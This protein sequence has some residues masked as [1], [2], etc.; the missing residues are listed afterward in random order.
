MY[1]IGVLG[2]TC[3]QMGL[4]EILKVQLLGKETLIPP[5]KHITRY[6]G[7]YILYAVTKG[8]L[9]LLVNGERVTLNPGD[10]FLFNKG[11]FQTPEEAVYCEY[12]YLH[13]DLK[14]IKTME[15]SD[16]DYQ[17]ET[18]R[19]QNAYWNTDTYSLD[20]YENFALLI[21]QKNHIA[22]QGVF[23]Y[24]MEILKNN[25]LTVAGKYPEKR[26]DISH[27]VQKF[28][29]KL[30][31]LNEAK[32]G[33]GYYTATEI[34]RY[35]ENHFAEEISAK[36]IEKKFYISFDYANRLFEKNM[37]SSII[38]YRNT[39]RLNQAKVKLATTS[40]SIGAISAMVGFRSEQYFCRAFKKHLGITPTEYRKNLW[41]E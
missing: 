32:R 35:V 36:T 37:K 8:Q 27:H 29:L 15:L 6:T 13:F 21:R 10:I 12:Y 17:K 38:R 28:F 20:C 33:K 24:L 3:F 4:N 31:S 14:E 25:R 26:L 39:V 40:L 22:D 30:E 18:E 5:T 41:K 9:R 16:E 19:R 11:D 7:E 2:M 23:E 34:A 1:E